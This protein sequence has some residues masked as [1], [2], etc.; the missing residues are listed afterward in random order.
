V[1]TQKPYLAPLVAQLR[2]MRECLQPSKEQTLTEFEEAKE[3][4]FRGDLALVGGVRGAL[5][6]YTAGLATAAAKAG[7]FFS[8]DLRTDYFSLVVDLLKSFT[9][10]QD[11][12]VPALHAQL[13]ILEGQLRLPDMLQPFDRYGPVETTLRMFLE[14]ATSARA[15][16]RRPSPGAAS[17]GSAPRAAAAVALEQTKARPSYH[18]MSPAVH[19]LAKDLKRCFRCGGTDHML[20]RCTAKERGCALC[21]GVHKADDCTQPPAAKNE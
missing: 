1:P 19:A 16:A 14:L 15:S 12:S 10:G 2:A 18:Y 7:E 17:A 3:R 6:L 4:R 11:P 8:V 13:R 9:S 21:G 20:D 5:K